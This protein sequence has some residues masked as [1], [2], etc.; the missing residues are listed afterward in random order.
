MAFR[1]SPPGT[2]A[3]TG[4]VYNT[5]SKQILVTRDPVF[6]HPAIQ[7]GVIVGFQPH[8]YFPLAVFCTIINPLLGPIALM[9]A[10]MSD[11]AFKQGDLRFADKWS[12]YA[13][14][15]CM[16]TIVASIVM[17]I[18]IGFSLSTIGVRG[19]HSY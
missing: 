1:P 6:V 13:F 10:I 9:F 4:D 16:V 15:T 2:T 11:R 3:N 14:F 5:N 18:A 7:N 12:Q 19:G 17:Y 8:A